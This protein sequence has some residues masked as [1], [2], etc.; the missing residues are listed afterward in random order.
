[1]NTQLFQK[2]S[3]EF[4]GHCLFVLFFAKNLLIHDIFPFLKEHSGVFIRWLWKKIVSNK[5]W[6]CTSISIFVAIGAFVYNYPTATWGFWTI[7]SG[8]CLLVATKNLKPLLRW[9]RKQLHALV[10]ITGKAAAKLVTGGYGVFPAA[11]ANGT[12]LLLIGYSLGT[13]HGLMLAAV[14][15]LVIIAGFI[16]SIRKGVNSVHEASEKKFFAPK[17]QE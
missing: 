3:L 17:D 16:F 14:G 12:I 1:M 2:K 11:V 10:V 15:V 5:A 7:V 4:L 8:V 13:Q 6:T 9:S